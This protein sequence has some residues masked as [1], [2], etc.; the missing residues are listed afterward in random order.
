MSVSEYT[1]SAYKQCHEC[2]DDED[3]Y[4]KFI[5]Y[6]C[7]YCGKKNRCE[8]CIKFAYDDD[9]GK[10]DERVK[11]PICTECLDDSI[12]FRKCNDCQTLC[13]CEF[14][15]CWVCNKKDIC[16]Y[17][18]YVQNWD[19]REELC[20]KCNEE[21]NKNEKERN[22]AYREESEKRKAEHRRNWPHLFPEKVEPK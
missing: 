16:D 13:R 21:Y 11:R 10:L 14:S 1:C 12:F 20:T 2:G 6:D 5:L 4:I 22:R 3:K 15:T 9:D 18:I 19:Y 17:C 7:F 8:Y